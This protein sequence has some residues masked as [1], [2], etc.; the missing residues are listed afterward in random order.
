MGWSENSFRSIHTWLDHGDGPAAPLVIT[1]IIILSVNGLLTFGFPLDSIDLLLI[2]G[3]ACYGTPP[4]LAG[5]R[6]K[7]NELFNI[8]LFSVYNPDGTLYSCRCGL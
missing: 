1:A 6:S 2:L 3:G 4:G 8:G 7:K 5:E